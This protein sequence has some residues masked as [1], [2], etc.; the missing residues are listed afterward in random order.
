MTAPAIEL[1]DVGFGYDTR[2][3]ELE[4]V[5]MRIERGAFVTIVGPNG[6]GKTT[7]FRLVLG[8][9]R[10]TRGTVRVL[11]ADPVRARERIGY[12][13]Q[14]FACDP[15]FP[16]RV[17]DVVRMG[18]LGGARAPRL[19]GRE[20]AAEALHAVGLEGFGPRWFNSLSG[21][22]RQR[23]LIARGLVTNPEILLLDEPTS[24]VDAT[25]E[26][27]IARVLEGLRGNM[28]ILLVTHTAAVASRF[29]DTI[30][31]VNRSVHAHP[32]TDKLDEDLMRHI[33]G[34]ALAPGNAAGGSVDA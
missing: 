30:Y 26:D 4:S 16:V 17:E 1:S 34:F 14:H 2:F 12:V 15:L 28:T 25:A 20:R 6:G 23:V 7:L 21:G 33:T 27:A 24:N 9:I 11:D 13:P 8:L 22:Q 31:C 19:R 18:C 10:P 5:N 32:A 3:P 29:L